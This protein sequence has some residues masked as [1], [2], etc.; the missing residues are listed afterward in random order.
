MS[1]LAWILLVVIGA[2][3]G[4][5]VVGW[6]GP[7]Q[8]FLVR[9]AAAKLPP[10]HRERYVEEW[11]A[12][13][14]TLPQAP[15]TR[16]VFTASLLVRRRRLAT[17]LASGQRKASK[18]QELMARGVRVRIFKEMPRVE[19]IWE[20]T[21]IIFA[22]GP[23]GERRAWRLKGRFYSPVVAPADEAWAEM[24]RLEGRPRLLEVSSV[25]F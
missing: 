17:E 21:R 10:R 13:L 3:V 23:D 14:H 2:L 12:E 7:A 5:E 16:F 4:A 18:L 24:D 19:K 15:L 20:H 1:A 22:E 9:R 6:C 25:E 11:M 8:R